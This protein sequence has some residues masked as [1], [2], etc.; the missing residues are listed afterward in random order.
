MNAIVVYVGDSLLW[1]ILRFVYIRE[2]SNN[3]YDWF[4]GLF[5]NPDYESYV[6]SHLWALTHVLFWMI[7]SYI[8]YRKNWFFKI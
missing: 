3:L 8:L 5:Y 6:G 2:P 1:K 4:N 7:V